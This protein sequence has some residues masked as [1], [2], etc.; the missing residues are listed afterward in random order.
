MTRCALVP[1][2]PNEL[3]PAIG[4]PAVARAMARVPHGT[5]SGRASKSTCGF[6]SEKLQASGE[7]PGGAEPGPS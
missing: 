1:P 7:S 5:R 2:N 3:T 6:G 4:R